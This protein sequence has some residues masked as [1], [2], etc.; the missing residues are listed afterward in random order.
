MAKLVA[1]GDSLSQ[2]SQSM[3]TTHTEFSFPA[4]IAEAM[5]LGLGEFVCPDFQGAGGLPFNLEWMLR[6]LQQEYGV[7][8]NLFEIAG[9]GISAATMVD[10]VEDYWERGKGSRPERDRLYNNLGIW[11]YEVSDSYTTTS[12]LCDE[13]IGRDKDEFMQ[14]S[15]HGRLRIARRVLNPAGLRS[16]ENY[17]QLDI[18]EKIRLRDG[19]I[20]HLLVMLGANNCLRSV[21][22]LNI[23]QT[24][25]S[26][27]GPG[28]GFT[29]WSKDAFA[30][31]FA[32]LANGV[33]VVAADNVY[34]GTIPHITICPIAHGI[35]EGGG[36]APANGNY[37]DYYVR[38]W[39]DPHNFDPSKDLHLTAKDAEMIDRRVDD[40]NEIIRD[41]A[42]RMGWHVADVCAATDKAAYRRNAGVTV[43]PSALADLDMRYMKIDE[44]G[45]ITQGGL[46]SL[47]GMHP[48]SCG[49][50][51]I[52]QTFVDVIKKIDPS[53]RDIDFADIRRRDSLVSSPPALLCKMNS[54]LEHLEQ[55]LHL[56]RWIRI[57]DDT[58]VQ[59][60]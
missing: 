40:Y 59:V 37:Y 48:T 43:L 10:E 9:A 38:V 15:S 52:A 51:L 19:E 58:G 33:Q 21:F 23:R 36:E 7:H 47:D 50:A 53:A 27:P 13:L 55:N 24:G 49:Y 1:I 57:N 32:R 26:S 34:V 3:A 6:R 35:N 41:T 45:E 8:L 46:V 42:L 22:D 54:L 11:N 2:G 17:T 30:E 16:K 56:S 25:Q 44:N 29:L 20:Q 31:E 14:P 4:M 18:A 28:S 5:G 60:G 39:I 12:K